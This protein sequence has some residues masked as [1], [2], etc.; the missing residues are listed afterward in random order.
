MGRRVFWS[1][2]KQFCEFLRFSIESL[3]EK[4]RMSRLRVDSQGR[5]KTE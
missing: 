4:S 3:A 2:I 1:I 5:K